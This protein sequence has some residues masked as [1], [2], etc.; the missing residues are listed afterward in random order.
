M[1]FFGFV[2][3][4]RLAGSP[5]LRSPSLTKPTTEGVVRLP[6]LLAITTGSLPSKTAT[7]ELVVPKSIPIIFPVIVSFLL[8]FSVFTVVWSSWFSVSRPYVNNIRPCNL[9]TLQLH[10]KSLHNQQNM[11]QRPE[12]VTMCDILAQCVAVLLPLCRS[13]C[14]CLF[15]NWR[16]VRKSVG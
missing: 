10:L 3:A 15:C 7:Q 14:H 12:C 8:F 5:I 13:V 4:C 9:C 11:C 2:M 1:V 6:S 16:F